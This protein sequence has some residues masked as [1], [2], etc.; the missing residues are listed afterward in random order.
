[1]PPVPQ[2]PVVG[3]DLDMT[4]VDSAAGIAATAQAA[5]A[6]FGRQVTRDELWPYVGVPL[7]AALAALVPGVDAAAV[8][9]R[10]RQLYPEHGIP[11]I[12]LLPGAAGALGAVHRAGGRVLIVSAKVEPAVRR[13]LAHV[14]LDRPPAAPDLVAGGLFAGAKGALLRQ[15]G[16]HVY[17]GDHPG[18]VEAARVAGAVAVAVTTGPFGAAALRDAGADVVLP[19]LRP[20][21]EWLRDR[22]AAGPGAGSGLSA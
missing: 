5:L 20:F 12:T 9:H 15:H 14:G 2:R 8:A 3:F 11:P 10:Y 1:V 17:V 7:E 4:L 19:D 22:F 6:E 13:V 16:A 21:P 18:D